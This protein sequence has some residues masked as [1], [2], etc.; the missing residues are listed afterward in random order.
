[1]W[2]SVIF[3]VVFENC[4]S[5]TR[6]PFLFGTPV[7]YFSILT[8]F[9]I[10]KS[11]STEINFQ[12]LFH[13][14]ANRNIGLGFYNVCLATVLWTGATVAFFRCCVW[15]NFQN[16]KGLQIETLVIFRLTDNIMSKSFIW[17]RS[18]RLEVNFAKLLRTPFLTEH[19]WWLLLLDADGL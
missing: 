2:I 16:S 13:I 19:L 1:M 10:K 15:D 17:I 12:R 18:S 4:V 3:V 6:R 9:A 8:H 5:L 11:W 14:L 7:F